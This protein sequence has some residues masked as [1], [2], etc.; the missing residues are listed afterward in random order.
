M[1]NIQYYTNRKLKIILTGLTYDFM[2]WEKKY[3]VIYDTS[4][5]MVEEPVLKPLKIGYIYHNITS[6]LMNY[7]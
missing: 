2:S 1:Y 3:D 6:W 5:F 4:H 7:L